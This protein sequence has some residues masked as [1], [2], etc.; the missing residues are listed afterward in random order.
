MVLYTDLKHIDEAFS[1]TADAKNIT[2]ILVS[3]DDHLGNFLNHMN[4]YLPKVDNISN[5][6]ITGDHCGLTDMI[7]MHIHKSRKSGKETIYAFDDEMTSGI[8]KSLEE[9]FGYH[10]DS[11]VVPKNGGTSSGIKTGKECTL[12]ERQKAEDLIA[13]S[14]LSNN[15]IAAALNINVR[16][17]IGWRTNLNKKSK[18]E[19]EAFLKEVAY[20]SPFRKSD[21]ELEKE[22][23]KIAFAEI[24]QDTY[25]EPYEIQTDC[26]GNKYLF[27]AD[28]AG[29][30]RDTCH[31]NGIWPDEMQFLRIEKIMHY[32]Q[33]RKKYPWIDEFSDENC[34]WDYK[35]FEEL[36]KRNN[37]HF[38]YTLMKEMHNLMVYHKQQMVTGFACDP[39]YAEVI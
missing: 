15:E 20:L 37:I 14:S 5:M 34:R 3:S 6:C 29:F 32:Y 28:F 35:F 22:R 4:A 24:Q 39:A 18:D 26:D 27:D 38:A 16:T 30:I 9:D 21:E 13:N 17:I 36:M 1:K 23:D 7:A 10:E 19:K 25:V 33:M 11:T 2:V 12:E 8:V 31:H